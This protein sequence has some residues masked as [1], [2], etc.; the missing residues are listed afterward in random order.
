MHDDTVTPNL[1]ALLP[2]PGGFPHGERSVILRSD[3][4]RGIFSKCQEKSEAE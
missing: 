2:P 1:R 3:L 4:F